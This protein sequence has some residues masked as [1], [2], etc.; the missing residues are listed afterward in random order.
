MVTPNPLTNTSLYEVEF[1]DGYVEELQYNIITENM[2]SQ[3][4]SE[5]YHYQLL[6]EISDHW[7]THLAITKKNG[8]IRSKSGNLHPKKTTIGWS[9]EVEWKDGSV[10]W[11]LLKDLDA[12]NPIKL[13]EYAVAKNIDEEPAFKWSVKN[14]L[15]NRDIIISKVKAKY[16]RTT[17]KFGIEVPK[18]INEAYIIDRLTG[19]SLWTDAIIWK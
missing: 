5:G 8:L 11:V 19:T 14:T 16:W 10:S 15:R 18:S 2:I 3:V 6:A 13:A 12:S 1:S 7:S 17:H 4:D 9:I